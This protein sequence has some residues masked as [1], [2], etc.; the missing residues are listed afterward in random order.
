MT[1]FPPSPLTS[2]PSSPHL[3]KL[4]SMS[5]ITMEKDTVTKEDILLGL[6]HIIKKN[7]T[8]IAMNYFSFG[9]DAFIATTFDKLRKAYP[10]VFQYRLVNKMVYGNL[11]L[12]GWQK[13]KRLDPYIKSLEVGVD[14]HPNGRAQEGNKLG[15]VPQRLQT[16][17]FPAK[18]KAF[19]AANVGSYSGGVKLWDPESGTAKNK[20]LVGSKA[21]KQYKKGVVDGNGTLPDVTLASVSDCRLEVQGVGGMLEMGLLQLKVTSADKVAQTSIMRTVVG[22]PGTLPPT[23]TTTGPTQGAHHRHSGPRGYVG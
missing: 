3:L 13:C 16:A 23:A 7:Y 4:S 10:K 22:M 11:G 12:Y 1:H 2:A 6:S 15:I 21:K 19:V 5:D 8:H 20:Y 9:M 18:T 14:D 17:T